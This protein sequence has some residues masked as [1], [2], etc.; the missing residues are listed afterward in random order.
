[1]ELFGSLGG[2]NGS[3]S[4]LTRSYWLTLGYNIISNLNVKLGVG[5]RSGPK[6]SL[7][8]KNF[9]VSQLAEGYDFSDPL[10]VINTLKQLDEFS[11]IDYSLSITYPIKVYGKFGLVP[12]LGYT[13]KHAGV[14][15]GISIIYQ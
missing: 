1:M 2:F 6:E 15:T 13:I 7:T 9:T 14:L 11:E 5:F 8:N 3:Y 10:N 4:S 12:E